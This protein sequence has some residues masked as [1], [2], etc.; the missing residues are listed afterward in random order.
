MNKLRPRTGRLRGAPAGPAST[1][2]PA[3]DEAVR[4]ISDALSEIDK[5][6]SNARQAVAKSDGQRE[7]L[8]RRLAQLNDDVGKAKGRELLKTDVDDFL[9]DLQASL[10]KK[11]V[12]SY[13]RLLTALAYDVLKTDDEI[14]LDLYTER[15]L[16]ALDIFVKSGEHRENIIDGCGGSMTNVVSLGL[17]MIATVR[18]GMR[19]FV[20]LDEPDCWI[21]PSKVPNFYG[22]IDD[23]GEK[24]D[25]QSLLISHHALELMPEGFA[26]SKLYKDGDRIICQNDPTADTWSDEQAGIRRIRMLNFMSHEDTDV[27]LAPG[28]T[29]IIGDNHIGKSCVIRALRAVT[30]GEISDAD[31]QHGCKKVAVEIEIEN[32]RVIR[33]TRQPGRNPVNEW[34]LE[35]LEGNILTD[36]DTRTEYRSGGRSAPDWV[37]V[38]SGIQKFEGLE[39]QL[40][41]QKFPVFLLGEK[42]STRASVLSIGRE[43]GYVQKMIER[44]RQKSRSDADLIK[45]GETEVAQIQ[46][47]LQKLHAFTEIAGDLRDIDGE[48]STFREAHARTVD[49]G[50]LVQRLEA[51]D[52]QIDATQPILEVL[53]VIP[54]DVPSIR[55]NTEKREEISRIGRAFADIETRLKRAEA[56]KSAL[57]DELPEPPVSSDLSSIDAL[58]EKLEKTENAISAAHTSSSKIDADLRVTAEKL[59]AALASA[60]NVCPL[61]KN[62]IEHAHDIL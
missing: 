9:Q 56:T 19:K 45:R 44:Q 35:D 31:I 40:S 20:A 28:A 10:H 11:S 3:A 46:E 54:D 24:L 2:A 37:G 33:L 60:G 38:I 18:S 32:G 61:C 8:E 58:I 59:D 5:K 23:V 50:R 25:M 47:Q 52:R 6:L 41:H 4:G 49:A 43:S 17:R 34:T 1:S 16:P 21:A 42:P 29:A 57:P 22:V 53:E 62:N 7:T 30:Y 27:R 26:I 36:A 13:E 15:G 48:L 39:H 51:A 12:G 55:E 14:G